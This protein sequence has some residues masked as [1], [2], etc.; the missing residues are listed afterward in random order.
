ML[1]YIIRKV[2]KDYENLEGIIKNS[3]NKNDLINKL[4][5]EDIVIEEYG[6]TVYIKKDELKIVINTKQ[7]IQIDKVL[8]YN[9]NYEDY[10]NLF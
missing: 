3:K 4:R 6:N 1:E 10:E 9:E 8:I 2:K 7:G 5:Q